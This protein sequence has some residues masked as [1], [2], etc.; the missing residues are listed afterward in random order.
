ME[1]KVYFIKYSIASNSGGNTNYYAVVREFSVKELLEFTDTTT[2]RKVEKIKV[3][4]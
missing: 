1:K 3:L 4:K 2:G